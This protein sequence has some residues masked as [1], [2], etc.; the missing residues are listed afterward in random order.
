MTYYINYLR[1][2]TISYKDLVKNILSSYGPCPK[3]NLHNFIMYA[4]KAYN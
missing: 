3:H 1:Y 4:L 2:F